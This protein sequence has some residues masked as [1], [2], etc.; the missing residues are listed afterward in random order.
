MTS[1][2]ILRYWSLIIFLIPLGAVGV[3][4]WSVWLIKKFISFFYRSPIKY[5]MEGTLSIVTPVYNENPQV[6][7]AALYSWLQSGDPDEIIAVIDSADE[8][9]IEVFRR[10]SQRHR[11]A[12]LIITE[13]P[14][15][16]PLH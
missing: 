15:K 11:I 7:E 16:R 10:F 1:E 8:K 9:C 3:W 5:L 4:R 12:K 6:F 13:T 14:G 2:E